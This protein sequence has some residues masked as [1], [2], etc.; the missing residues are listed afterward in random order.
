MR[1]S[2]LC[3]LSA[4]SEDEFPDIFNSFY[5]RL[6]SHLKELIP[7]WIC[8]TLDS[9]K[10]IA[11]AAVTSLRST[12]PQAKHADTVVFARTGIVEYA[13]THL[14]S[15]MDRQGSML[16]KAPSSEEDSESFGRICATNLGLISHLL[17]LLNAEQMSKLSDKITHLLDTHVWRMLKASDPKVRSAVY[18]LCT[19]LLRQKEWFSTR[20]A[21][22]S[23]TIFNFITD[24]DASTHAKAW[25]CLVA[26]LSS[27]PASSLPKVTPT[28]LLTPLQTAIKSQ[29]ASPASFQSL[30]PLLSTLPVDF[31]NPTFCNALLP[32]LWRAL[33]NSLHAEIIVSTYF[34]CLIFIISRVE[35]AQQAELLEKHFLPIFSAFFAYEK[36]ISSNIA[37]DLALFVSRIGSKASL[38]TLAQRVWT[39][40][41]TEASKSFMMGTSKPETIVAETVTTLSLKIEQFITNFDRSLHESERLTDEHCTH[42]LGLLLAPTLA[43][44]FDNQLSEQIRCISA[45]GGVWR[46]IPAL[47][48]AQERKMKEATEFLSSRAEAPFFI[49]ELVMSPLKSSTSNDN[50]D[51]RALLRGLVQQKDTTSIVRF[52]TSHSENQVPVIPSGSHTPLST[53]S[54]IAITRS[55]DSLVRS[56][57]SGIVPAVVRA[58]P[59][60]LRDPAFWRCPEL[61]SLALSQATFE[62][63]SLPTD[64]TGSNYGYI[65]PF[66]LDYVSDEAALQVC[67]ELIKVATSSKFDWTPLFL[68]NLMKSI[69]AVCHVLAELQVDFSLVLNLA[70]DWCLIKD[71]SLP[72]NLHAPLKQKSMAILES[73]L[74]RPSC[75]N[76]NPSHLVSLVR[77]QL[78]DIMN[79]SA[80]S[81][82]QKQLIEQMS[83][84]I[85]RLIGCLSKHAGSS[86]SACLDLL[87]RLLLT[88]DEWVFILKAISSQRKSD[89][90]IRNAVSIESN[91]ASAGSPSSSALLSASLLLEYSI[92]TLSKISGLE[93]VV[94][95]SE[96]ELNSC[97]P[98]IVSQVSRL[99]ICRE[100]LSAPAAP[101]RNPTASDHLQQ[102]DLLLSS[103]LKDKLLPALLLRTPGFASQLIAHVLS[104]YDTSSTACALLDAVLS[105]CSQQKEEEKKSVA[106]IA[107]L[108]AQ[109]SVLPAKQLSLIASFHSNTW[110]DEVD[111]SVLNNLIAKNLSELYQLKAGADLSNVELLE[112]IG[113]HFL[114]A[115]AIIPA[116]AKR[117]VVDARKLTEVFSF[118]CKAAFAI[119]V[120]DSAYIGH[121]PAFLV[122][123]LHFISKVVLNQG[124][125]LGLSEA[126]Y[127]VIFDL[128]VRLTKFLPVKDASSLKAES[129]ALMFALDALCDHVA[130]L[131]SYNADWADFLNSCVAPLSKSWK[132]LSHSMD[133][134]PESYV[135]HWAR[136]M[137]FLPSSHAARLDGESVS[138]LYT[139]LRNSTS[140]QVQCATFPMLLAVIREHNANT[141]VYV[142]PHS[143]LPDASSPVVHSSDAAPLEVLESAVL[144]DSLQ[145]LVTDLESGY[146]HPLEL[147]EINLASSADHH[148]FLASNSLCASNLF[149]WRLILEY[150]N[151]KD[152]RERTDVSNWIRL[153]SLMSPLMPIV[154]DLIDIERP[155]RVPTDTL[156][157]VHL[158][159]TAYGALYEEPKETL[160]V[161]SNA[162][163]SIA[164]YLFRDLFELVPVLARS[165]WQQTETV[166]QNSVE[167]FV[168]RAISPQLIAKEIERV[169]SWKSKP[170]DDFSLKAA[171]IGE[172]VATYVKDEVELQMTLKLSSSHPLRPVTVSMSHMKAVAES[173]WRKWL[174]SMRSLLMT[175]DGSVLDAVLLWR[176]YLDRHFEGV[177]CCPICYA[178]FHITTYS[179]PDLA[180][181]TCRNK[182]H[183]ACLY[184]W[185]NSSHHNECPLCKTPF[186]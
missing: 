93:A 122:G 28:T 37:G 160:L 89:V 182:F 152:E 90:Y 113:H 5:S 168:A 72:S 103:L 129:Y 86:R 143:H 64:A 177:D 139:L 68:E 48:E 163:Q 131:G 22:I 88:E 185:F 7:A 108:W 109:L 124:I 171:S 135:R 2:P 76:I 100:V 3:P 148:V 84:L 44:L 6:L 99:L 110:L 116:A 26:L 149:G 141:S 51:W 146:A 8:A 156:M 66:L 69:E 32:E 154:C 78:S 104:N 179:L 181:K 47:N 52:I 145:H 74:N 166:T 95:A 92:L 111:Q 67:S 142:P 138:Q 126:N 137:R 175:K 136:V 97:D 12:I 153:S 98:R 59:A 107:S 155:K 157:E 174:L 40:L 94:G 121:K 41:E 158:T 170:M 42:F 105:F 24:S 151:S 15:L 10:E 38:R 161:A 101:H 102:V 39:T 162:I 186:N 73:I 173:M 27:Y 91:S 134:W 43:E 132:D 62:V 169:Q 112:S 119:Y 13:E 9:R 18:G 58:A 159:N 1:S 150:M 115:S 125:K 117:G 172:V 16:S 70:F 57:D 33:K 60:Q 61:D 50:S 4:S 123:L 17:D 53:S 23:P 96:A 30:L 49:A 140:L 128:M 75:V 183:R 63:V 81:D 133:A 20:L 79:G 85:G 71:Q 31:I 82:D 54:N 118:G 55:S 178:I 83:E 147:E 77:A 87:S 25:G 176:N 14:S 180:C 45:L 11:V 35:A 184:K 106:S 127:A 65:L 56:T 165:W 164:F 167:S 46:S 29:H 80:A 120:A 34:E 130:Q 19:S 36:P 144:S 21:E 114:I